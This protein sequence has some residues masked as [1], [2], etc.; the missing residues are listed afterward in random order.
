MARYLSMAAKD[1]EEGIGASPFVVKSL[2][3]PLPM[4]LVAESIIPEITKPPA[5]FLSWRENVY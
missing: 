5:F 2:S 1:S 3:H 4:V